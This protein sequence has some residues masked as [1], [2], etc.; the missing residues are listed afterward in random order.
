MN[1]AQGEANTIS[2]ALQVIKADA[3][4]I[5]SL[6]SQAGLAASYKAEGKELSTKSMI[7]TGILYLPALS[8]LV[9]AIFYVLPGLQAAL[10][11][12]ENIDVT[13]AL[14][15]TLL[16][17]SVL[18]PLVYVI[19]FT[20]KRISALETLRLDYA[21]KAAASLAYSG[22]RDQM[23]SDEDLLRQLKS[24][25]LTKFHEHPERL[26]RPGSSST[27]ARVSTPGL[28][29]ETRTGPT[30]AEDRKNTEEQDG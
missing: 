3:E 13:H 4:K 20:T 28:E 16:R 12:D 9:I 15:A 29:L 14:L 25:L 21:E 8:T 1:V 6:S 17:A 24:S 7:F 10:A 11:G 5:L 22:Y 26:L 27:L 30:I 18:A 19:Y 23:T 2:E